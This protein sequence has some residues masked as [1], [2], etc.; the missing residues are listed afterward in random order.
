MRIKLLADLF[1]ILVEMMPDERKK[2]A[3]SDLITIVDFKIQSTV[4]LSQYV[5]LY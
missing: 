2:G 4:F 3:R 5:R 1:L